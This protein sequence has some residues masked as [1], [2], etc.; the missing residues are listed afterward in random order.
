MFLDRY[1]VAFNIIKRRYARLYKDNREL[2]KE[3]KYRKIIKQQCD[4]ENLLPYRVFRGVEQS[5]K[6]LA[7]SQQS[8]RKNY[9]ANK[10]EKI[11]QVEKRLKKEN[12]SLKNILETPNPELHK[13]RL[14][15]RIPQVK[16][17]IYY[18]KAR[19]SKLERQLE[20]LEQKQQDN[21]FKVCFG[22]RKMLKQRQVISGN[23]K[24]SL[25]AWKANWFHRRHDDI[26]SVGDADDKCGNSN[27]Q[28]SKENG[29]YFIKVIVPTNM[30]PDY[31]FS[32]VK[33]PLNLDYRQDDLD[34]HIMSHDM[35]KDMSHIVPPR[36][37]TVRLKRDR[38]GQVTAHLSINQQKPSVITDRCYGVIGVDINADHLAIAETDKHGNLVSHKVIP[39]DLSGTSGQNEHIL[40]LAVQ[41]VVDKALSTAKSI[42]IEDLD[43]KKKKAQLNSQD[44]TE[45]SKK[46]N[47]M[48]SS[49][50]YYKITELF[51][52]KTFRFGVELIKVNPAYT[53]Q[54]GKL[55]YQDKMNLTSHESASYVI[56]R[57]GQ[58]FKE[59]IPKRILRIKK[60]PKENSRDHHSCAEIVAF[61]TLD[62]KQQ[63]RSMSV[64]LPKV[65]KK[66][67]WKP[68]SGDVLD[69]HR[70]SLPTR[71]LDRW[72][73]LPYNRECY[74]TY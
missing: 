20:V 57:R 22:G 74:L 61:M 8:N 34:N 33:V 51:A 67:D 14:N 2:I 28:V 29:Q 5:I 49:L 46:K 47:R 31:S 55:K 11:K 43:F 3:G 32:F 53:S 54:L 42:I 60:T 48:L 38:K 52:S 40:S 45:Y 69:A 6:G 15:H 73:V 72:S 13:H 1:F 36:P 10:Q 9:I 35:K 25:D 39:Y 64:I 27:M 59:K 16:K 19:L 18:L 50:S 68:L 70:Q 30:R 44:K 37:M 71:I 65:F 17:A 21:A 23:D 12:E 26:V 24:Q 4:P 62:K 7:D 56:A 58:G 63:A 66:P 41:E